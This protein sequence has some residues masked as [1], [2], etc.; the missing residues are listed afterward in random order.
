MDSLT[1]NSRKNKEVASAKRVMRDVPSKLAL[2]AIISVSLAGL[3]FIQSNL[4][5]QRG[6]LSPSYLEPLQDAPPMLA[7]VTQS[8]G[9]FRGL[10]SSYL[11]L[12]ANEMQLQKKYQEQMQL[13]EWVAQ[14]QPHVSMVWRNRAW[15]MAYNISVTYPDAETRWKYVSEGVSLLRDHGIKYNPQEPL[16]YH[17]LGW[18][19]QH[20]MGHNMDDH[21]RY[22]KLRWLQAMTAVL[23]KDEAQANAM[24]GVP[25]FDELIDPPNEEVATRVQRLREEYKLDPREMKAVNEQ[26]GR[27]EKSDGSVVYALDWRLPEVQSLYWAKLGLKRCGHNPSKENDLRKLERIVFQSM[28]YCFERGRLNTPSGRTISP[29]DYFDDKGSVVPN[30]ELAGRTHLAYVEMVT[31]AQDERSAQSGQSYE[32]AHMNFL[33]RVV[34]WNYYYGREK[35]SVEWLKLALENYPDRMTWY[36]GFN[37]E[38]ETYDLEKFVLF[39]LKDAVSRGGIDKTVAMITGLFLRHFT[40]LAKGE[41]EEAADY[42]NKAEEVYN[43]FSARFKGAAEN[44]VTLA[45]FEELKIM[46]LIEYLKD[47]DPTIVAALRTVYGLKKDEFP[48]IPLSQPE[49]GVPNQ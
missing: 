37:P 11:W 34:E 41:K 14:L 27:V 49:G 28:M 38:T 45:T 2:I 26:Y 33:K 31:R 9:G 44:R 40:H 23:W 36:T 16:I 22:Y 21:H 12:R 25:N 19:F 3:F 35:E 17:E 39:R 7:L 30:M 5:A 15:N 29:S 13:S 46:R 6:E 18:I 1:D 24:R 47:E 48:E 42:L 43:L 10:I 20:K 32:M 4:N 8:L